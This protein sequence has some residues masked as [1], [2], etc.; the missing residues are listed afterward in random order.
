MLGGPAASI[1]SE[2]NATLK[3][4]KKRT[5]EVAALDA[6][7]AAARQEHTAAAANSHADQSVLIGFARRVRGRQTANSNA[8]LAG[9]FALSRVNEQGQ[10]AQK[11]SANAGDAVNPEAKRGDNRSGCAH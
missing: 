9:L 3:R 5:R 8:D 7:H 4:D 2:A 1:H 6:E 11:A 10:Q